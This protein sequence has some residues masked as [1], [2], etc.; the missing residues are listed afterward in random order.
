MQGGLGRGT[1]TTQ[2]SKQIIVCV[3]VCVCVCP[4]LSKCEGGGGG[5]RLGETPVGGRGVALGQTQEDVP[6]HVKVKVNQLVS[7]GAWTSLWFPKGWHLLCV[8]SVGLQS[9]PPGLC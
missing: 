8:L 6:P 3:C 5:Q 9:S 2:V 4:P 7:G 1:R